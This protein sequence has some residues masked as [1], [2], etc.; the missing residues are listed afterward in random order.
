MYVWDGW[1][2][3]PQPSAQGDARHAK[4]T[5]ETLQDLSALRSRK[6]EGAEFG[7]TG[8]FVLVSRSTMNMP[9][10]VGI[11]NQRRRTN[12]FECKIFTIGSPYSKNG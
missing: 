3:R 4:T 8:E 6:V 10:A 12:Y 7:Q 5:D 9:R 1:H 2:G 11:G